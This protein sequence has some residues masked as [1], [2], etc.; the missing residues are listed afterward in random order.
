LKS[1]RGHESSVN[2]SDF[3]IPDVQISLRRGAEP[4]TPAIENTPQRRAVCIRQLAIV[5]QNI[6]FICHR[7]SNQ[8][9][10][11]GIIQ[12]NAASVI[13]VD[14]EGCR[15][16]PARI[17]RRTVATAVKI[18]KPLRIRAHKSPNMI[19]RRHFG[20]RHRKSLRAVS[21]VQPPRIH[22]IRLFAPAAKGVAHP[23]QM[24]AQCSAGMRKVLPS[25]QG[26]EPVDAA[27]TNIIAFNC[28]HRIHPNG[29]LS[30]TD[31]YVFEPLSAATGDPG[32]ARTCTPSLKAETDGT[33]S[34][35]SNT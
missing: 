17:A 30:R 2:V 10:P 28:G 12:S 29:G 5:P 35:L 4:W 20:I 26:D 18:Y 25:R 23:V 3:S 1:T 27:V 31:G 8:R 34:L 14:H 13:A 9:A 15:A 32:T 33:C 11:F 22:H 16:I 21:G 7:Q 19:V 6:H 24:F